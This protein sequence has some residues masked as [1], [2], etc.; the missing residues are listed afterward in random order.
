LP[1]DDYKLTQFY[2]LPELIEAVES[3]RCCMKPMAPPLPQKF[4]DNETLLKQCVSKLSK[5]HNKDKI[6][7]GPPNEFKWLSRLIS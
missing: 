1:V 2:K 5:K 6:E 3:V 7:I 4:A